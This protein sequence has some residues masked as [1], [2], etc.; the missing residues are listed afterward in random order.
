[1]EGDELV[2][3]LI[4][5]GGARNAPP[6]ENAPQRIDLTLHLRLRPG[7][8]AG[9]EVV[10][11]ETDFSGPDGT[12]LAIQVVAPSRPLPGGP[13]FALSENRPDP[14]ADLTRFSLTLPRAG[15]ADLGVFDITGRR[16]ATLHHGPLGAG[17]TEFAWDGRTIDGGRARS[18]IYFYRATLGGMILSRK[19]VLIESR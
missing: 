17:A 8:T 15:I 19:M 1:M 4:Q 16:I 11:A 18:G 5:V 10:P 13:A 3:G 7:M 9:G 6:S 2:V 12:R 14:F